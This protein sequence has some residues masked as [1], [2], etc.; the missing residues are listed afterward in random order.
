MI[1]PT[2]FGE[3]M[4]EREYTWEKPEGKTSLIVQI[5]KPRPH[6]EGDWYCCWR[7]QPAEDAKVLYACGIDSLQSLSLALDAIKRQLKARIARGDKIYFLAPEMDLV[8]NHD[9]SVRVTVCG[10]LK[11]SRDYL[12]LDDMP[13]ELRRDVEAT[14]AWGQEFLDQDKSSAKKSAK[15]PK[16]KGPSARQLDYLRFLHRYIELHRR[17]PSE[18]EIVYHMRVT[19][20]S[21][22]DM[23]IKLEELGYIERTPGAARSIRLLI[24]PKLL[25]GKS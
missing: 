21:A 25:R 14:M 22:H 19:A 20:P 11:A 15:A 10:I 24:A 6:P 23:I 9:M 3:L 17:P 13:A 5:D 18:S 7:F 8:H 1:I 16:V 12:R 2:E 4:L